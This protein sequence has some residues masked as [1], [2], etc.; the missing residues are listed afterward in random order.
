MLRD[1]YDKLLW[2][3]LLA[4]L[5]ALGFFLLSGS[6]RESAAL[7]S[8]SLDRALEQELAR[9]AKVT[10]VEKIYQPVS[11]LRQQGQLQ[12]ALLKLDELSARYPGE[13]HGAILKGEILLEMGALDAAV[14]SFVVAVQRNGE[15]VDK[16]HPLSRNKEIAQLVER[17]LREIAPRLQAQPNNPALAEQRK[18]LYYLQSRLAGGC[19]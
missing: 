4:V 9:Q 16:R 12:S 6:V 7:D 14:S 2:F 11:A 1:R 17:G 3:G 5:G 19:E 13:A 8:A 18:Q 10:F 15:Y